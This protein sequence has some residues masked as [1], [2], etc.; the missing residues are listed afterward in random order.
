MPSWRH[1]ISDEAV[2]FEAVGGMFGFVTKLLLCVCIYLFCAAPWQP[3]WAADDK[4]ATTYIIKA[5]VTQEGQQTCLSIE[6][7]GRLTPEVFAV[8]SPN[9]VVV[10]AVDAGFR[11]SRQQSKTAGGRVAAF[12]YGLIGPRHARIVVD[13]ADGTQVGRIASRP[14]EGK[15]H[16]LSISLTDGKRA[17]GD[18]PCNVSPAELKRATVW[19]G[20][21]AVKPA[22]PS[23]RSRPV[24][25]V[26]PGHGGLD[27]GAVVNKVYLEKIIAL[28]VGRRLAKRLRNGGRFDVVMTRKRDTFVSLDD[29]VE[30]ARAKNGDVFISLHADSIEGGAKAAQAQ[31]AAV[32]ILS[33]KASDA[34]AKRLADKENSADLLAGILPKQ[35]GGDEG[36][37]N[38]LVDLLKRETEQKSSRLQK[39]L[40][41]AMRGKV[42]LSRKP[43]RSAAFRVLKQTET[44][45]VL[46][47]LGYMTNPSDLKRM[48]QADWQNRMAAAI[49]GAIERYFGQR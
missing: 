26:D 24:V 15:V 2:V 6:S 9:R 17:S 33:H 38:I 21:V 13:V 20:R 41:G 40:V 10:D 23:A 22:Q 16:R 42:S 45:A 31:G 44:P 12:R 11:L 34:E 8:S 46:I 35:G 4:P 29:R 1:P 36:V 30:R 47:E 48:R 28:A 19:G 3:V 39:L 18:K 5:E 43:S 32:Y 27:P 7:I 37:R 49:A 25:V 14:L